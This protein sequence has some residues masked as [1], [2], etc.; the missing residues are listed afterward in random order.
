MRHEHDNLTVIHC[1]YGSGFHAG[2][3][4]ACRSERNPAFS[5]VAGIEHFVFRRS[6]HMPRIERIGTQVLEHGYL[7]YERRFLPVILLYRQKRQ[8]FIAEFKMFQI[9]AEKDS[10]RRAE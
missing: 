2:S 5:A 1:R 6:D 10:L 4:I 7:L 9:F 8:T 3:S